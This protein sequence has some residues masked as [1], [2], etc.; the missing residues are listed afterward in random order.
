MGAGSGRRRH[1]RHQ[2]SVPLASGTV[3][4]DDG[5][6]MPAGLE[7]P[8][9]FDR[10]FDARYG[11]EIVSENVG[12]DG[13]VQAR[14]PVR[15]AILNHLGVVHGGVYAAVAEAIASR[16]TA[17]AVMPGGRMAMGLS[18]DTTVVAMLRD[19]AI[20]ADA[21][22]R[23]RGEDAWVWTIE[24]RDDEG[25]VCALSRVTVAVR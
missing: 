20:H 16:G 1:S 24:S 18:N 6:A 2:G 14:V 25:R 8:V 3:A 19:G 10:C 23:A 4:N 7:P 9:P 21:R 15:D 17:L 11:L 5:H 12:G 22:V 13:V